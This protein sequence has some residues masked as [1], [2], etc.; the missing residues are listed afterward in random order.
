MN[1]SRNPITKLLSCA[2]LSLF[3]L[4]A[5][6]QGVQSDLISIVQDMHTEIICKSM[7]QSVE[8][9]SITITILDRKGMEDARFICRCDMFS[10]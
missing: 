5:Q 7:T 3:T 9:Q 8:K 10:S 4:F 1:Y 6:A 2:C